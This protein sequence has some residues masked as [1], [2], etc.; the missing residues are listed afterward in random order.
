MQRSFIPL[1]L[2]VFFFTSACLCHAAGPS[3]QLRDLVDNGTVILDDDGRSLVAINPDKQFIPAST[4][5]IATSILA[6]D[7][8]GKDFRFTTPLYQEGNRLYIKGS[9]DPF[10]VSEEVERMADM[11]V[12]RGITA[13]DGIVLDDTYFDLE[14]E[15]FYGDSNNPYDAL[16]NALAVNFNTINVTVTAAGKVQSAEMQ[17]PT[18]PLMR[19]LAVGLPPG[20]HR[21]S[22]PRGQSLTMRYCGELFE[23][24]FRNAGIRIMN[25]WQKGTLPKSAS[26]IL[27][28]QSDK[29][30]QD[31]LQDMLLYSNNFMANQLFLACAA[32]RLGAP[33]TWAKARKVAREHFSGLGFSENELSL[34]EG[35][36]LSRKN[37]VTAR[38]M[39]R[40]LDFFQPYHALLPK[41]Q[42]E[43]VKSGTLQGV[44]CYAGYLTSGNTTHPFVIFLNQSRNTRNEILARLKKILHR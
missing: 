31:L 1:L 32:K 42:G 13:I 17:T 27:S 37:R 23:A 5:K 29:S 35:S 11:L 34:Q 24:I 7:V 2:I 9:G 44:Y 36:G 8:L 41:H 16:N 39:L 4:L 25:G 43:P 10:L 15:D 20:T 12:A 22:L 40:L 30:L 18:L 21:I 3:T 33:A 14:K 28:F 6:L 26:P 38:A 19:D